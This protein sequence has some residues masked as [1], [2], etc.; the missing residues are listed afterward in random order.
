ML[1]CAGLVG[2]L[3]MFLCS[4]RSQFGRS[5]ERIRF[6]VSLVLGWDPVDEKFGALPSIIGT[7]LT[8]FIALVIA[9]PLSFVSAF[10]LVDLP[11]AIGK[12]LSPAL[13]L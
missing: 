12:I 13:D 11:G 7:L 10:Y 1:I 8:T 6:I 9:L 4:A 5:M 3:M 2:L